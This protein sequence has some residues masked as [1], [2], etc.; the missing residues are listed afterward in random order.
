M[1]NIMYVDLFAKTIYLKKKKM[2]P[3]CPK[4]INEML[5][6]IVY[7]SLPNESSI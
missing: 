5:P 4:A 2:L 3:I 7:I 1:F 6:L